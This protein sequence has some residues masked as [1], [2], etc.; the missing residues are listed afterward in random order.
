MI[1]AVALAAVIPLYGI[2]FPPLADLPQQILVNKLLWEKLAGVSHLDLEISWFLGYRLIS[3]VILAI[4]AGLK[5]CGASLVSLPQAIVVT[6]IC[7]HSVIVVTVLYLELKDRS[8]RS[9]IVAVCLSLPAVVCMYSASWFVGFIGFTLGLTLLVPTIF[10][11]ERFIRSGKQAEA[12][13]LSVTLLVIYSAHPF[14][15]AFWALWCFSRA[16][17]TVATMSVVS[18]WKKLFLVGI[19][20]LPVFLYHILA[21]K[22]FDLASGGQSIWT[23]SPF[24]SFNDWYQIRLLGMLT[25]DYLKADETADPRVFGLFSIGMI[26]VAAVF[27]FYS[28]KDQLKK[29]AL[30]SILFIFIGSWINEKFIPVPQGHWLAYDFRFSSAAYIVCLAIAAMI[31]I[32]SLPLSTDKQWLKNAFVVL[33]ILSVLTSVEHLL[34]VRRAYLRF[35]APAREYIARTFDGE[36]PLEGTLPR[37]RWYLEPS[38][39]RR[40]VCLKQADYNP[41]GTLFRNLG[42]DIYP[43]KL[44]SMTRVSSTD[45]GAFDAGTESVSP[46]KGGEGYAAGQFSKPRGIAVDNLG[47]FYVADTGNSR[48]QKF[49]SDGKFASAFGRT[50]AQVL[51]KDPS[52]LSID[53]AGNTYV[54]DAANHK[55]VRFA[56]DGNFDKEWRGPQPGLFG[57]RDIE[58][59]PNGQLYI[60]DQGQARVVRFDPVSEEFSTFGGPGSGDGQFNQPT[61]IGLGGGFVF[62]A[63]LGNNRIQVLDLD[64]KFIRQFEVPSWERYV[65]NYADVAYEERSKR[66]YVTNGWRKEVLVLDLSGNILGSL[67]PPLPDELNNASSLALSNNLLYVLNT[68]SDA[69]D[70]GDPKVTVF[71]LADANP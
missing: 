3:L 16:L 7:L 5:F 38:F 35:D 66:L 48:V 23:N 21:A 29:A 6:L 62:V 24:V 2:L 40:Y 46:F 47:N 60:I 57:P 32:R 39:L 52:G 37:S 67:K 17:T 59:G 14:V 36:K 65:W 49:G 41:S 50:G 9:L 56:S 26:A 53:A 1:L 15:L 12:V 63:D 28:G 44:R 51:L 69:F 68:G 34:D 19:T 20:F 55:L 4:I 13:L 58:I 61:G 30:S 10:L 43:V 18:E 27:A 64:G 45:E 31:L 25:G 54:V 33:G 22:G 70:A 42:G 8:H 11:T 71:E